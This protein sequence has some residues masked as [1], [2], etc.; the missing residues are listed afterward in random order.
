MKLQRPHLEEMDC[1]L[2]LCSAFSPRWTSVSELSGIQISASAA[3][4]TGTTAR[5]NQCTICN[6]ENLLAKS[7]LLYILPACDCS[8]SFTP[9]F[10]C[11]SG[12]FFS[13]GGT[14]PRVVS[15]SPG[16]YCSSTSVLPPPWRSCQRL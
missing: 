7:D 15:S 13:S 5:T 12:S 3:A 4:T 16:L 10:L 1:V 8:S 11:S 6:T 2:K 9:P 14:V